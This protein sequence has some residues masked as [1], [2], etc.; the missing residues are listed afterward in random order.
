LHYSSFSE[1]KPVET[2][3]PS[4]IDTKIGLRDKWGEL[5]IFE[6]KVT[7]FAVSFLGFLRMK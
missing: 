6:R 7:Y 2:K 3:S 5:G 1:A 4:F